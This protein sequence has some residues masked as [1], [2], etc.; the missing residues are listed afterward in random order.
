VR[1][2]PFQKPKNRE[3]WIAALVLVLVLVASA[4][5]LLAPLLQDAGK[6]VG[7]V[8]TD[9]PSPMPTRTPSAVRTRTSVAL[10]VSPTAREALFPTR[11]P[12][13]RTM[14]AEP[15]LSPTPELATTAATPVVPT[16]AL[17][18]STPAPVVPTVVPL[19]P[20]SAPALP[21]AVPPTPGPP[22]LTPSP[23]PTIT[24][25]FPPPAPPPPP[26]YNACMADPNPYAAPNYPVRILE[27]NKE[28]EVFALQ[29]V[30][31]VPIDLSGWV[32]CSVNGVQQFGQMNVTV[33]PGEIKRFV[34]PGAAVWDNNQRDDAAL[35]NTQGQLISYWFNF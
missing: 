5:G 24:P 35:Y 33:Q 4:S 12:R 27:V 1:R 16:E 32:I 9:T 18:T 28:T 11:T 31:D 34:Y 20:T 13:A 14:T 23:A 21:T 10:P 7:L 26:S 3:E 19:P 2:L 25:T 22:T 8:A 30:G 15:E 29:N 6:Q 17:L